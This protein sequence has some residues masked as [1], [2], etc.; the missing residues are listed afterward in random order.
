M[1]AVCFSLND[2]FLFVS[3]FRRLTRLTEGITDDGRSLYQKSKFAPTQPNHKLMRKFF[4]FGGE[5]VPISEEDKATIKKQCNACPDFPGL[6]LLGF[7][8]A[9]SIPCHHI[10]KS[11][12]FVYPNDDTCRGSADAFAHLH[13]SMLRKNVVGIGEFLYR[14]TA[15]SFLVA[16]FPL[17][18]ELVTEEDEDGRPYTRQVRPPGMRVVRVPFEDEVRAIA[19]DDA[20][21]TF[22][23]TGVDVAPEELVEAAV[24]LVEKQ[25]INAEL[26]EDFQN[27]A[28][29][30]YWDYVESVALGEGK[31]AGRKFDTE[32]DKDAVLKHAGAEIETF[33]ALLPED[34]IP[35]KKRK[36]RAI[37]PDDTGIDWE[38]VYA[39]GNLSKCRVPELKKKLGAHGEQK[40]GVKADVSLTVDVTYSFTVVW[41]NLVYS[42]FL[43][44]CRTC[45][46]DSRSGSQQRGRQK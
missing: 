3:I 13:T 21:E 36:A 45:C 19:S 35:E 40:T 23:S 10:L 11:P 27:P 6:I 37:E 8:P 30:N 1:F 2:D 7:K 14:T 33:S 12:Y 25:T 41:L 31:K 24:K 9:D 20:T 34:I 17:E 18:E 42:C 39:E 4:E 26:G 15:F 38:T 43:S 29:E 44:A 46:G 16:F 5:H 22:Q 32:I 28:V